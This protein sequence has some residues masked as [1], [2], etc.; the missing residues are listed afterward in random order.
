MF[1]TSEIST[2]QTAP[3]S[4]SVRGNLIDKLND[5]QIKTLNFIESYI[6]DII[7]SKPERVLKLLLPNDIKQDGSL[8]AENIYAQATLISSLALVESNLKNF[9]SLQREE[10]EKNAEIIRTLALA[11]I[12]L[13]GEFLKVLHLVLEEGNKGF[14]RALKDELKNPLVQDYERFLLID[15][16]TLRNLNLNPEP[17]RQF[18]EYMN[19]NNLVNDSHPFKSLIVN[20]EIVYRNPDLARQIEKEEITGEFSFRSAA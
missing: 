8:A 2:T 13:G 11:S 12:E 20:M 3:S 16:N 15:T 4:E 9:D 14:E 10:R 7:Q 6:I 5:D 18:N 17:I 19:D 1:T